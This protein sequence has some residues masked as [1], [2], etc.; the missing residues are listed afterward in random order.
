MKVVLITEDDRVF[1]G[2][3]TCV[4]LENGKVPVTNVKEITFKP[5]T[6]TFKSPRYDLEEKPTS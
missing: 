1:T 4:D 5:R 2:T 6:D 3:I